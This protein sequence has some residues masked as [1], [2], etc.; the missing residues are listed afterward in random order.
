MGQTH[1][2]D[3]TYGVPQPCTIL[4]VAQSLNG[5]QL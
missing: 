5:L 2:S 1:G 3:T 4:V